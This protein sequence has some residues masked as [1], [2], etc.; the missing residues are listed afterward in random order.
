VSNLLR[1]ADAWK[2]GAVDLAWDD[3]RKV[4]TSRDVVTGTLPAAVAAGATGTLRVGGSTGW[5]L[6]VLNPWSG[7]VAAGK[8]VA[9]FALNLNAWVITAADCTT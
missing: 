6:T 8:V 7:S 1:R 5:T 2:T 4:W 3:V 9:S